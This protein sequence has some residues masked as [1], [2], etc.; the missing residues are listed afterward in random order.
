MLQIQ[1]EIKIVHDCVGRGIVRNRVTLKTTIHK[2]YAPILIRSQI[3]IMGVGL[4]VG[5]PGDSSPVSVPKTIKII[6][7]IME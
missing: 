2:K 6:R 7:V 4:L 5:I 1:K 3:P